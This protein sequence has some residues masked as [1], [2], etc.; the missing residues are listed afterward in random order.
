MCISFGLIHFSNMPQQR[1]SKVAGFTLDDAPRNHEQTSLASHRLNRR[2]D[3]NTSRSIEVLPRKK[4]RTALSVS[5]S[6]TDSDT[7]EDSPSSESINERSK[8]VEYGDE[9][10]LDASSIISIPPREENP[11]YSQVVDFNLQ[12]FKID[13]RQ[14][15]G[16]DGKNALEKSVKRYVFSEEAFPSHNQVHKL[17]LNIS[18]AI[19]GYQ[20]QDDLLVLDKGVVKEARRI[21]TTTRSN[22]HGSMV[23]ILT[24]FDFSK[25]GALPKD[26]KHRCYKQYEYLQ[27]AKRFARC[28]F[29]SDGALMQNSC[30]G[31]CLHKLMFNIKG[32][33]PRLVF[34][35]SPLTKP[36]LAFV[37]ST[38][39]YR[40]IKEEKLERIR[41]GYTDAFA[42]DS[43]WHFLYKDIQT[44]PAVDWELALAYQ[45]SVVDNLENPGGNQPND[46]MTGCYDAILADAPME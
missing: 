38:M 15:T 45:Q 46:S 14:W 43:H 24:Q 27:D 22:A 34:R 29:R 20:V 33:K 11:M 42:E 18:K 10:D 7:V 3:K 12:R 41:P 26:A 13:I 35:D 31:E 19:M 37:Y 39:M 25:H 5:I 36:M 2:K 44:C 30:I 23:R 16:G 1:I 28:G 21:I 9:S 32:G 6:D 4:A 8:C 40:I 17:C